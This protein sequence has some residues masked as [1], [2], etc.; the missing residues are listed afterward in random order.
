FGTSASYSLYAAYNKGR[1]ATHE[2]GHWFN[3][4]HIWGDAHCGNDMV[5]DTP[6]HDDAN[7]GCP[8]NTHK[9]RC[10]GKPLEQWMNYMDYTDDACMY[11]FSAGQKTRM[12][13]AIDVARASYVRTTK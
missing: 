10:S 6:P 11:M 9:S 7:Y 8:S 2:I 12:D 1:S 5:S 4:R 13:A 3:L